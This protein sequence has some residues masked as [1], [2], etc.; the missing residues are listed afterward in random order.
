M[1]VKLHFDQRVDLTPSDVNWHSLRPRYFRRYLD[2]IKT[3]C[4]A[5]LPQVLLPVIRV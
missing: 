4:F 1:S 5:E 2:Y 3:M